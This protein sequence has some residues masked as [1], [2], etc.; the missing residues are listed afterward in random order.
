MN[1]KKYCNNKLT[2]VNLNNKVTLVYSYTSLIGIIYKSR[3]IINEYYI[4]YSVTTSKHI[5]FIKHDLYYKEVIT[6][7]NKTF[8]NIIDNNYNID[9]LED[10]IRVHDINYYIIEYI[11]DYIN[12]LDIKD[13]DIKLLYLKEHVHLLTND[14]LKI[15]DY[16]VNYLKTRYKIIITYNINNLSFK[17]IKT[18]NINNNKLINIKTSKLLEAAV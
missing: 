6:C 10:L 8:N 18:F 3:F 16:K 2:L 9:I 11:E 12:Y 14:H 1:I 13:H 17:I 4:N 7:T 15:I 5:S